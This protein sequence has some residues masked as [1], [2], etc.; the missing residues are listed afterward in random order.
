MMQGIDIYNLL[1]SQPDAGFKK[2]YAYEREISRWLKQNSASKEECK[3]VMHDSIMAFYQY[4]QKKDFD[5]KIQAVQLL[6]GIAKNIW[7]KELRRKRQIPETELTDTFIQDSDLEEILEREE[8]LKSMKQ[9]LDSLGE[10]CK[11][12]LFLFYFRKLSM[13]EIATKLGFRNAHVAKSMKYQCLDKANK[14]IHQ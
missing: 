3:D 12:L 8:K 7:F 11:E 9:A 6:F 14:L 13:E 5:V 4:V 1:K 2:L 10:P